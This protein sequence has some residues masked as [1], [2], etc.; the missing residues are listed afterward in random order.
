MNW[1]K[2]MILWLQNKVDVLE[3]HSVQ[4]RS[5]TKAFPLPS[6]LRLRK[7]VRPNFSSVTVKLSRQNLF[8]RD[9]HTCQ[10]CG[11]RFPEKLL[12]IDHVLPVSKGGQHVWTNVVAACGPCNN[13]K[14]DLSTEQA[15]MPLRKKPIQPKWLPS[16]E[17]SYTHHKT[18]PRTWEPYL[19]HVRK[20]R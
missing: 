5:A 1:Q 13:K 17:F 14:G 4:V 8:I 20:S 2:A 18:C 7:Y 6:V 10:Y 9:N 11:E 12:T 15:D 3:Y 16:K 19:V